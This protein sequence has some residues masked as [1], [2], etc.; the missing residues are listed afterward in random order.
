M[1]FLHAGLAVAGVAAVSIPIIIHLLFRQ[2]RRPIQWAAMRFLLEAYRK[3]RHRMRLE[4]LILLAIRCLA[5]GLLGLALAR[6]LLDDGGVAG[7]GASRSVYLLID[8]GLASSVQDDETGEATALDTHKLTAQA[9]INALGPSDRVGLVTLGE[10]VGRLVDPPSLDHRAVA[11]LVDE[12]QPSHAGTDVESALVSLAESLEVQGDDPSPVVVYL[13][14]QFRLGSTD[15]TRP[16]SS[17]FAS[18][19]RPVTLLA[20][21]PAEVMSTN[22]QIAS[23]VPL[24]SV[25]MTS[26]ADGSGQLSIQLRRSGDV[27]RPQTTTLRVQTGEMVAPEPVIVSWEPGESETSTEVRLDLTAIEPGELVVNVQIDRDAL[28]ADDRRTEV[29]SVRDTINVAIMDRQEFGGPTS[30]LEAMSA[31]QWLRRALDPGSGSR[32]MVDDIDPSTID[33]AALRRIDVVALTRP[34]LLDANG[35]RDLRSF[36]DRGGVLWMMPPEAA[37]VALWTD[38]AREMLELPWTWGREPIEADDAV[39]GAWTL[40]SDQPRS[41]LF[42]M[43]SGEMADLVRPIRVWRHLPIESGLE[44]GSTLLALEDGTPLM[45]YGSPPGSAGT[46]IYLATS[47]HLEWTSLPAKPFMVAL[48]QETV[49]QGL[50]SARQG[51]VLRPGQR[52]VLPLPPSARSLRAPDGTIIA[53]TDSGSMRRPAEPLVEAGTYVAEDGAD[54][55]VTTLAVNVDPDASRVDVQREGEITG[56]L[57]GTGGNW[58]YYDSESPAAALESEVASAELSLPLLITVFILVLLET[59]LARLFS[60]AHR[61][62]TEVGLEVPGVTG[63]LGPNTPATA[64]GGTR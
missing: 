48:A 15:V 19:E 50:G 36:V 13:I 17:M 41:E 62:K 40:N 21:M 28:Q 63:T 30:G 2:R 32:I 18:V 9:V 58:I 56:W 10:P 12:I 44:S 16:L 24:R 31:G 5:I 6:P 35:W 8:N 39:T 46:V 26:A 53:L 14:S 3:A 55:A 47:P 4:Q 51:Q 54:Q 37:Q 42:R 25:A 57:A 38:Q 43:L 52:P 33:A 60:H 45:T 22:V 61:D 59:V 34:D 64:A 27:N 23:I 1:T 20:T 11:R 7:F 49:R 29:L